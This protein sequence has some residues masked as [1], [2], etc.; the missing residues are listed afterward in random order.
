[1]TFKEFDKLIKVPHTVIRD[2]KIELPFT[3]DFT[4]IIALAREHALVNWHV[5]IGEVTEDNPEPITKMY[6]DKA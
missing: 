2:W 1:M 5:I 6:W 3:S 4:Q